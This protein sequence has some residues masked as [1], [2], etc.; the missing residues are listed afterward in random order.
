MHFNKTN[1]KERREM[2]MWFSPKE[3]ALIYN[4]RLAKYDKQGPVLQMMTDSRAC[5]SAVEFV[6]VPIFFLQSIAMGRKR[7]TSALK[8]AVYTWTPHAV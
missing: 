5:P 1:L 3:E 4:T 6:Y 2:K 7:K 8:S